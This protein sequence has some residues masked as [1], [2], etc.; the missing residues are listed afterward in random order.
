MKMDCKYK[1]RGGVVRKTM[2]VGILLLL[3]T[4]GTYVLFGGTT[5]PTL[6]ASSD[7]VTWNVTINITESGGAGN[8]VVFGEADNASNGQDDCDLPEPPFP[9]QL[10]YLTAWFDTNLDYPYNR[11]WHNYKQLSDDYKQWNLSILWMSETGGETS[12]DIDIS[13][14]PF[15][16][17]GSGYKSVLL[18]GDNTVVADMMVENGYEFTLPGGTPYRFQIICQSE[19]T[20]VLSDNNETPF[21]PLIFTL[22]TIM[23]FT[24]YWKK[25]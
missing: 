14:D 6:K 4:S 23:L 25:K 19:K 9:P 15:Q 16:L 22:M 10:P 7:S 13:W 18:Y 1:K 20:D 8:T 3:V 11:L 5:V 21:L 2:I 17:A 12:A 24:L